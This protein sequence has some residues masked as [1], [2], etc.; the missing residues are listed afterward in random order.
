MNIVLINYEFPPLGAGASN[1]TFHIG[2][3]LAAMGHKIIVLTSSFKKKIGY[4]Y[5]NGMIIFR[6]P[7]IRKKTSE[8][9]IVEMF[10]FVVSCFFFIP[11]IVLKHKVQAGIIFFSFPCGPLGLLLKIFFNIPYIISLRG[12]DVPGNEKKLDKIHKILKPLRR[13]I[14]KKSQAVVANSEGLKQLAQKADP[15]D[16]SIIHNGIDTDFFSPSNST[17]NNKEFELLFAGRLSE[18]KNLPFLLK[19]V[20]EFQNK[21]NGK[22]K[23]HI[24]GDGPLKQQIQDLSKNLGIA[25]CITWHGWVDKN[26]IVSLCQKLDCFI[27][28]S[29]CEGMPNTVLEAMACGLPVIASNVPGNNTLVKDKENGYLFDLD[30]GEK[31]QEILILLSTNQDLLN[32]LGIK[33]QI[34]VKSNFSWQKTALAYIKA[35]TKV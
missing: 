4:D 6:C 1:A 8:S 32:K 10:S 22:I 26:K 11:W 31:I 23:L 17:K 24:A 13:F 18:Q 9:N 28:P 2:K 30:D 15:I 16:I 27:N 35:F 33:A 19:Q 21:H 12:G 7:A 25:D 3:E 20:A 29:L 14:F 5:E 34:M